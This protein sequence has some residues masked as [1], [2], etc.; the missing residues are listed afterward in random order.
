MLRLE[1]DGR[2]RH[3]AFVVRTLLAR[4]VQC[5]ACNK[6]VGERVTRLE[7]NGL[8]LGVS[9]QRGCGGHRGHRHG[10]SEPGKSDN[11]RLY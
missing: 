6:A 5:V 11:F 7:V 1:L 4:H 3:L 2:A 9:G 8:V 10:Y